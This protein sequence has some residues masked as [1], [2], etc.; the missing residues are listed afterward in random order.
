MKN[1][2]IFLVVIFFTSCIDFNETEYPTT[3]F[4]V[5]NTSNKTIYFDATVVLFI[6]KP[7]ITSSFTVNPKDSVLARSVGIKTDAE[8]QIWFKSF[9]IYPVEGIQMNDPNLSA[10]WVKYNF[11]EKPTYVFTLNKN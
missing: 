6:S 5:K 7:A 11:N 1:A 9:E 3:E 2:I 10:N 8:P 4:Y